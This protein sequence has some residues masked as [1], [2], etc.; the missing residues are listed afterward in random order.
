MLTRLGEA[1][2]SIL[3]P[4]LHEMLL[5]F[6]EALLRQTFH[7]LACKAVHTVKVRC[8]RWIVSTH[9]RPATTQP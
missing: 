1:S 5:R 3:K 6:T 9:D 8:C 2:P 7:T 4:K